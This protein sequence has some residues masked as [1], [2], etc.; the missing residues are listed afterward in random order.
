MF[1]PA[2]LSSALTAALQRQFATAVDALGDQYRRL[3][4]RNAILSIKSRKH[5]DRLDFANRRFVLFFVRGRN[6]VSGGIMSIFSIATET[7]R[8]L[9]QHGVSVAICT[10]PSEPRILRYTKFDND[11]DILAFGD[12]LPRFPRGAEVL[13]HLPEMRV[14]EFGTECL[15]VYGSRPDV[16]WRFNVLLQNIDC[17]PER[18]LIEDLRAVG[19]VT[20]T[21]AHQAY[22]D[23][24]TSQRIGCPVHF[25]SWRLSPE[26]FERTAYG[27]KN[28]LIVISPDQDPAKAEIVRR[29]S[30]ELADHKIVEVRDM[31]YRQYL[32][33]IKHAKFTFTFGEGLDAYFIEPV[34]FGGVSMAIFNERF[35][36]PEYRDLPGVFDRKDILAN[37]TEFLRAT[38]GKPEYTRIAER[39]YNFLARHYNREEYLKNIRAFYTSFFPEWFAGRSASPSTSPADTVGEVAR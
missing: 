21:T 22:S 8:L 36:T 24:E 18:R 15:S 3:P 20:A 7:Q 29:M 26:D 38:S 28:N 11:I 34:F 2:D 17:I 6:L 23:A 13:V 12:L 14:Q 32:D 31:T 39:Q 25:L 37:V 5:A 9:G 19:P 33:L 1:H 27:S 30:E 35:F 10:A 16:K 4:L